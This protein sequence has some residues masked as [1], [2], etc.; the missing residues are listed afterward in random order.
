MFK[1]TGCRES[2]HEDGNQKPP[3]KPIK[4]KPEREAQ[5]PDTLLN[6]FA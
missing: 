4:K 6:D 5:W 2:E 1:F 3:K